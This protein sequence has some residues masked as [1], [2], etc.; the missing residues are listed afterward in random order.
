MKNKIDVD[1]ISTEKFAYLAGCIDCDGCIR[2]RKIIYKGKIKSYSLSV[3]VAQKDKR[4][5]NFCQENFGGHIYSN[6]KSSGTLWEWGLLGSFAKDILEKIE[7]FLVYKR[8]QAKVGIEFEEIRQ[9]QTNKYR[10][11]RIRK[12]GTKG[13]IRGF[14]SKDVLQIRE[15]YYQKLK[16]L[17]KE[18]E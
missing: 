10:V 6:G 2:I 4:I 8:N 11:N 18:Y 7:P 15:M 16:D 14:L 3:R 13:V 12:D 5:I 1:K 17:K 9:K